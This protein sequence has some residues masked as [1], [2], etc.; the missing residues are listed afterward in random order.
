M[1]KIA[2]ATTLTDVIPNKA[3]L[4]YEQIEFFIFPVFDWLISFKAILLT[5]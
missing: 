4:Q 1:S 2:S 5:Y 3:I